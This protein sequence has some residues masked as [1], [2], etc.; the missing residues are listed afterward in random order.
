[1]LCFE[2]ES[3]KELHNHHVVPRS[4]GGTKTIVLCGECHGKVHGLTA[5]S[6]STLTLRA[7]KKKREKNEACGGE[8]PY[9]FEISHDGKTLK[10]SEYEQNVI[11]LSQD[12][13]SMGISLRKIVIELQKLSI[14]SRRGTPLG[15]TQI[16]R[17]VKL[18][19]L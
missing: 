9:G 10:R 4:L 2:C 12:L 7:M 18:P 11:K 3:D 16:S 17:I 13:R 19:Q 1:M 6:T 14:T 5:M 15:L 8:P